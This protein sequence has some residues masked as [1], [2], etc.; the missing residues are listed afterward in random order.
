[1]PTKQNH[2]SRKKGTIFQ[3]DFS[4]KNLP[5]NFHFGYIHT[6]YLPP[7][8]TALHLRICAAQLSSVCCFCSKGKTIKNVGSLIPCVLHILITY[9]RSKFDFV[10]SEQIRHSKIFARAHNRNTIFDYSFQKSRSCDEN[11]TFQMVYNDEQCQSSELLVTL[12][13]NLRQVPQI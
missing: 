1:M 2:V 13:V 8:V 10:S 5:N 9:I 11:L 12:L 7:L 4:F 6:E 3:L